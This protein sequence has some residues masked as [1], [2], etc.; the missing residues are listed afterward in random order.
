MALPESSD[1]QKTPS[2]QTKDSQQ[3]EPQQRE[4]QET[5]RTKETIHDDKDFDPSAEALIDDIDDERTLEEEEA[6]GDL[7]QAKVQEELDDL[8][9]ESE[10]P[11]EEL[12][13][14]YE[15]MR[16]QEA[17]QDDAEEEEEF[18]DDEDEEDEEEEED[19]EYENHNSGHQAKHSSNQRKPDDDKDGD[20]QSSGGTKRA[21]S[22]SRPSTKKSADE[23][24]KPQYKTDSSNTNQHS[25]SV[26]SQ[27]Q[28]ISKPIATTSGSQLEQSIN[29]TNDATSNVTSD[30]INAQISDNEKNPKQVIEMNNESILGTIN[31][32]QTT[33]TSDGPRYQ[34]HESLTSYLLQHNTSSVFQ[35]LLN[36]DLEDSE[37]D[38]YSYASDDRSDDERDWRRNI[39]V[40]PEHQAEVPDDLSEYDNIPPYQN[41]DTLVW[42]SH[43][44][45][46]YGELIDYLKKSASIQRR[47]DVS[48]SS[49]SVPR[50]TDESIRQLKHL[51]ASNC[52]QPQV[53]KTSLDAG[54]INGSD[55]YMNQSRKRNQIELDIE[56]ENT[57]DD[58]IHGSVNEGTSDSASQDNNKPELSTEDYFHD[59][60]QLLYLLLQCNYNIEEALRRR[61]LDP[62]KY[63]FHEP[64]SLWSESEC[65]AFESGLRTYGK[66]FRRIQENKVPTRTH[67]ELVAFYYL[68]K[69]SE[70]HDVYTNRYKLDRKRSLTH[71]GT[72]DYMDNFIDD[73]LKLTNSSPSP[74][75]PPINN[76]NS[77]EM[78]VNVDL[79][80]DSGLATPSCMLSD[81][82]SPQPNTPNQSRLGSSTSTSSNIQKSMLQIHQVLGRD[83][84]DHQR[85]TVYLDSNLQM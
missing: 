23:Q 14:Y 69:K 81:S 68:W 49:A 42:T 39:H 62:F 72:T 18:E 45:L 57:M 31:N 43:P 83:G 84:G 26:E 76:N 25:A 75:T 37:D 56:R 79:C 13:A 33:R 74:S 54:L 6:H 32:N 64:M 44:S 77:T 50:I 38:D 35:T 19:E 60:E 9:K 58:S 51:M 41:H 17:N 80:N 53:N 10:M 66:N 40:G 21:S 47:K 11:I 12:L 3:E 28:S 52:E 36:Y 34:A 4:Q 55:V 7:N 73:T 82:R 16:Q 46:T 67:A 29:S 1:D 2:H 78:S 59:E 20:G 15:S 70:R 8:K 61:T 71:P 24:C 22:D 65:L 30:D 85:E 48:I 5:S 27:S 63:Y